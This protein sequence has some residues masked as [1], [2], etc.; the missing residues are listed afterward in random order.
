MKRVL[1]II[2]VIATAA[3][4]Y[5]NYQQDCS[6][7]DLSD[8]FMENVNALAR[9]ESDEEKK[10]SYS[11]TGEECKVLVGGAYAKGKKVFCW[12][13]KVHPVCVDCEL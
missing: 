6:Q 7:S 3:I 13:G 2:C 1:G 5:W 12:S 10:F 11:Y 8:L 9:D 4:T